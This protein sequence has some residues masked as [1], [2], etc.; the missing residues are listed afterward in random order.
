MFVAWPSPLCVR[1]YL[2]NWPAPPGG[3]YMLYY[4][5]SPQYVGLPVWLT[6]KIAGYRRRTSPSAC[7]K[8]ITGW[9][10]VTRAAALWCTLDRITGH[11]SFMSANFQ[12]RTEL[13]GVDNVP[14]FKVEWE[15][16]LPK[17]VFTFHQSLFVQIF[18][19]IAKRLI[20]AWLTRDA[21]RL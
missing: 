8:S 20:R 9:R 10:H 7:H 19:L 4:T 6:C 15:K 3:H 11:S 1:R 18:V 21:T 12:Q 2:D 14:W 17:P 13:D 16:N 5:N